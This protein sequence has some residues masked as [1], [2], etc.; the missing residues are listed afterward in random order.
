M[1]KTIFVAAFGLLLGVLVYQLNAQQPA[2]PAAQQPAAPP[3][4]VAVVDVA[5][6]IKAHPQF[7]QKQDALQSQ[8]Q[9]EEARL[10]AKRNA[11]ADQE[12]KLTAS[13]LKPGT[14]DYDRETETIQNAYT[15]FEKEARN[16]NR[17]FGLE[18]S[19][20]MY[21]TYQDIKREIGEYARARR[22]AQVTDYRMVE[23]NPAEP[24]TVMEDM[25]QKL[26]WFDSQ[27]NITDVII[28][29][30]QKRF[31]APATTATAPAAAPR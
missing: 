20:I 10:M 29:S 4:F 12:K 19:K 25:D 16:A 15:E 31:G 18:S 5:Q 6:L 8:V 23:P 22:I 24:Q 21:E 30:M 26:V 2:A 28:S 1:K 9:Q 3:V 27:L 7:Q 13:S 17:R 11:I 14:P